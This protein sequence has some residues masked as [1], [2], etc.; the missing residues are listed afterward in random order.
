[1]TRLQEQLIKTLAMVGERLNP[2]FDRE[3]FRARCE[4]SLGT[5]PAEDRVANTGLSPKGDE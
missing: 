2:S 5:S 3:R 1:M 4:R